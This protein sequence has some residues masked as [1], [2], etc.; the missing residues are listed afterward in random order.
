MPLGIDDILLALAG[1]AAEG[2]GQQL[3]SDLFGVFTSDLA[4]KADLQNAVADIEQYVHQEFA[5]F[6]SAII[7]TSMINNEKLLADYY[8]NKD[9]SFL[10]DA[11]VQLTNAQT[12]FDR[13][14]SKSQ[15][16]E[17]MSFA[18]SSFRS[19]GCYPGILQHGLLMHS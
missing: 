7:M 11:V 1:K 4:T 8:N 18:F 10:N 19:F 2:F 3:A 14:I 17:M 16:V 6:E 12:W 5:Q 15:T 13:L 9:V